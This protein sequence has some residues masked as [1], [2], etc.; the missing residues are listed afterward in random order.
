MDKLIIRAARASDREA[1]VSFST[2]IWEGHDYLPRVWDHWF[3]E[4]FGA[5]LVAELDGEPVG[6]DKI[7]VLGPGEIWMEGLRVDPLHWG[8]G[9]AQALNLRAMEIVRQ[10]KPSTVRFSTVFDNQASRHMGEKAGFQFL[11][12]CRRMLAE[13]RKGDMP[14]EVQGRME[15]VDEI[16]SFVDKSKHSRQMKRLFAWGWIFKSLDRPFV[17]RILA[18]DG[19][20]V[21][22]RGG[23][24]SGLALFLGQRHGPK[25]TLGFIDGD[26]RTVKALASRFRVAAEHRGFRELITMVPESSESL[27]LAAGFRLEE[28]T[29]VVVYELSGERLREAFRAGRF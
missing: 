3:Q 10:L 14:P 9:I 25:A 6:T 11:F 26:E 28:P 19:A 4:T 18:E 17:E 24:I 21:A 2:Q 22:R 8:K 13:A 12:Q 5:L 27:L 7:T 23:E 15:D 20:L 16:L 29:S 1:V